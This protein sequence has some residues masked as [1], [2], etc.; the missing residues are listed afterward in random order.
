MIKRLSI[1]C[2][3]LLGT[4][5]AF[6][7]G[8]IRGFVYD[9]SNGEPVIF[10]NVVLEGTS[11]GISTD[12]NG[13]YSITDV[14][15]GTYTLIISSVEYQKFTEEIEIVDNK[16]KSKNFNLK[17]GV[18]ELEGA[19]ISAEKQEQK[20]EVNMSVE[21]V[22]PKEIKQLPSVGGQP[23]L[24]QYLQVLPGVVFTGDQGGQLY[25]RGGSPVQNKVLMDGMIVYQP[26]HSIGLFSVFD[27]DIIRN[28]DVYTGGF[29]AE[30]GGRISSVMDIKTRDGNSVETAGKVG[31]SPFAAKLLLEGPIKKRAE[32]GSSIS[33]L[34]SMKHSYL[35]ESS[36]FLYSYID[37]DGLP[38]NFTDI[39]SKITFSGSNGSKFNLYGF[40]FTDDVRYRGIADLNWRNYGAGGNF[41][42]IPSGSPMLISGNFSASN[43]V[44]SLNEESLQRDLTRRSE[45]GGFNFGLDF[46]YLKGEDNIRYGL[47]VVGRKT[48]FQTVNPVGLKVQQVE[49]T[50][51]LGGYLVYKKTIG[52]LILEPS[53]RLQYY[54]SLTQFS[55]E[56]RL[57]IKYNVNERFR[58]KG[59]VGRYS[60]NI[61][62]ANSDRD[63]VNLFYGFLSGPQN[64]QDEFY[65][66]DGEVREIEYPLQTANHYIA[67]F[68]FD[69]TEKINLNVEG[70]IKD[71]TQLTNINR[72]KIFN[73]TPANADKP[74]VLTKDYIV[75]SGLAR[76]VDVVIKYE[77][78]YSYFWVV[79]SLGKIT[80][81]D[82]IREYAPVFDRRHNVNLVAS[83]AF[84]KDH[85]WEV[86]AR[87][88]LGS[89]LPFTQTQGY[90]EIPNVNQG[91]NSDYVTDNADELGILY[92]GLNEGRLPV[93]HRLDLNVKRQITFK[94]ETEMQVTAG[95]T[96]V[97]SRSN[98]FY[99]DR[100]TNNRVDQLP[101][102]PSIGVEYSF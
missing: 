89:G 35:E 29:N 63:V 84:G 54:A 44:V 81:W 23:D 77:E 59:A 69:I 8:S 95:V 83:Q 1:L 51:E 47:Q 6:S 22:R 31:I 65:E 90:Y 4:L 80:R 11:F 85:L 53:F 67:G 21:T 92:A 76:G 49:N 56:P 13:Y 24:A 15:A 43:Y 39:Y 58:V 40:N 74:E 42:V 91:I 41:V 20:T 27:T 28:A 82:G 32:N 3:L 18:I 70:Y 16:V 88:N 38:F 66:Q 98:V 37:E 5:A 17:K 33:Y 50:T 101:F 30:F 64:L 60:Q 87:W 73:D 25:I 46:K 78:K 14:P 86:S 12:V 102:M 9:E 45:I 57:G 79:Y 34:V 10:A 100:V 68:E 26:F 93:Y 71:F 99:I 97:Y 48:D 2:F 62:A 52:N 96:N 7:Q 36:K 94:N 55:P 61:I 72:N 19:E 75:E